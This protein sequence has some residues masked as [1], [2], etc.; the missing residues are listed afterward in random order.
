MP[1][2]ISFGTMLAGVGIALYSAWAKMQKTKENHQQQEKE[3]EEATQ[4][5]NGI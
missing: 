3:L 2:A 1:H 4:T 5:F